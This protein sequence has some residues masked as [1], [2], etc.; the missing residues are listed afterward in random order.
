MKGTL[1][2]IAKKSLE[3]KDARKE[4]MKVIATGKDG[5]ITIGTETY[6][7]VT[8]NS[9]NHPKKELVVD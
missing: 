2:T 7:I 1:S 3:D 9:P 8:T 5:I 4:V 6:R